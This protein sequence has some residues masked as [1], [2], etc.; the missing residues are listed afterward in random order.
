MGDTATARR[1]DPR[2]TRSKAQVL[3]AAV[4]LLVEE[5]AAGFTIE[6]VAARAGVART[7]IYRHWPDRGELIVDALGSLGQQ[8]TLAHTDDLLA[9]VRTHLTE[10]AAG[11]EGA[12]W[13]ALLPSVID[14]AAR[15]PAVAD[16]A[17]AF[18]A[19][20]RAALRGRLDAAVAEGR[21]PGDLD[22]DLLAAQL[23]GPLFYRR[24]LSHQPVTPAVIDQVVRPVGALLAR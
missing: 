2:V 22:T 8:P 7:T 11:L 4:A 12:T 24:L 21:L 19:S 20:R 13:G 10:L 5:G 16:L 17:R 23:V 18:S 1:E 3:D 9:D 15:D 14:A 6:K